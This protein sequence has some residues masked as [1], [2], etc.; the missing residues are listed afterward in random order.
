MPEDVLAV[1]ELLGKYS[2]TTPYEPGSPWSLVIALLPETVESDKYVAQLF[3]MPETASG[4]PIET[5]L[6]EYVLKEIKAAGWAPENNSGDLQDA[7]TRVRVR[8]ND[9]VWSNLDWPVKTSW[10]AGIAYVLK[11]YRSYYNIHMSLETFEA[12]DVE[13]MVEEMLKHS[14]AGMLSRDVKF[15]ILPYLTFHGRLD[16]L[17]KW[18]MDKPLN[19]VKSLA[20]IDVLTPSLLHLCYQASGSE[21]RAVKDI[22]AHLKPISETALSLETIYEPTSRSIAFLEDLASAA[23]ILGFLCPTSF[24]VLAQWS[25]ASN[26]VQRGIYNFYLKQNDRWNSIAE[27]LVVLRRT[28][29]SKL[30]EQEIDHDL[31]IG[32]LRNGKY[33]FLQTHKLESPD[34][35]QTEAANIVAAFKEGGSD[36]PE[37]S[38][39]LAALDV[40]PRGSLEPTKKQFTALKLAHSNFG[41]DPALAVHLAPLDIVRR[42]L[43][44]NPGAYNRVSELVRLA[45][46]FSKE[47]L[48]EEVKDA[49]V[50]SSL[51]NSDF[52][53]AYTLCQGLEGPNAWLSYLQ[54]A[55]FMSPLWDN[56]PA[57]VAEK[58]KQLIVKCLRICPKSDISTVARVWEDL[59]TEIRPQIVQRETPG[60][61]R[62]RKR[63]HLQ[64]L[65]VGGIGWAIG[66]PSN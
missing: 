38:T 8:Q 63:D 11:L 9:R 17:Q 20:S 40:V 30:S 22:A 43:E 51:A 29:F 54:A 42:A 35:I 21:W 45:N 24:E 64:K 4:S 31:L 7:F 12:T 13:S 14:S 16:L 52:A 23:R 3:A 18:V 25:F 2:Y 19:Y 53:T 58:Q 39:V 26:E 65:L 66:A 50:N 44:I 32:A 61:P 57:D 55:K 41:V 48:S 62:T 34:T 33:N 56:R 10:Y 1:K 60:Q 47:N 5:D 15:L 6:G 37:F 49:C 46:A 28:I 36:R 27:D 59:E